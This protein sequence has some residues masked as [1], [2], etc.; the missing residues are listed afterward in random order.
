MDMIAFTQCPLYFIWNIGRDCLEKVDFS[1]SF[2]RGVMAA[3]FSEGQYS[4]KGYSTRSEKHG[5][6]SE[7]KQLFVH[8]S[9]YQQMDP[10]RS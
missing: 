9:W 2:S 4:A 5:R 7:A 6:H 3:V 10:T 8:I 1:F